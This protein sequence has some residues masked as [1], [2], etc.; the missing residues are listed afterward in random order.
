MADTFQAI[1]VFD[2]EVRLVSSKKKEDADAL[3]ELKKNF[4]DYPIELK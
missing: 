2:F 4:S 3:S 1:G